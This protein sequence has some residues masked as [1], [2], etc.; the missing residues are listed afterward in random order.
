MRQAVDPPPYPVGRA[1]EAGELVAVLEAADR[2]GSALVL[3]GDAGVGKS[4]LLRWAAARWRSRGG[5]LLQVEGSEAEA[6]VP[7]AGLR[8]LLRRGGRR[9]RRCG[10]SP[11]RRF[12]S[13]PN[14]CATAPPQP[15]SAPDTLERPWLLPTRRSAC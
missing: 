13:P 9:R 10:A 5:R 12:A 15:S 14:W 11:G 8:R 1:A 4:T 2:S 7:Y 3:R 6:V